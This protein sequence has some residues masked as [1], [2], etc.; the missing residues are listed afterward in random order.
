[1][2]GKCRVLVWFGQA[3]YLTN[4]LVVVPDEA[5]RLQAA[6]AWHAAIPATNGNNLN[7]YP[8]R[9]AISIRDARI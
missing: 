6:I 9:S 8:F 5:E 2:I 4:I 3:L 1:M 7:A